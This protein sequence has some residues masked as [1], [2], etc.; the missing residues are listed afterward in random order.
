VIAVL[1]RW[2]LAVDEHLPPRRC[3]CVRKE[4]QV[5]DQCCLAR[6]GRA[7]DADHVAHSKIDA[8]HGLRGSVLAVPAQ[9]CDGFNHESL[10]LESNRILKCVSLTGR[11]SVL[12]RS[13]AFSTQRRGNATFSKAGE[14]PILGTGPEIGS[15]FSCSR[16]RRRET[17]GLSP[18]DHFGQER[19]KVQ[20]YRRA[21]RFSL[22]RTSGI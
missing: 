2:T 7:H 6:A 5:V 11:Y 18:S 4:L 16:S 13:L 22:T 21:V 15:A 17:T 10:L 19:L 8:I 3:V 1:D 14:I 9:D 12:V 20:K